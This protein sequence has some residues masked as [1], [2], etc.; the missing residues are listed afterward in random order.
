MW[1]NETVTQMQQYYS[2]YTSIYT[3]TI[4]Q[5][6]DLTFVDGDTVYILIY[7]SNKNTIIL[8]NYIVYF[9]RISQNFFRK[10]VVKASLSSST[11]TVTPV[12]KTRC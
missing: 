12:G 7:F 9:L 5:S 11:I 10:K 4:L 1:M 8:Q 6:K 3:D 2:E